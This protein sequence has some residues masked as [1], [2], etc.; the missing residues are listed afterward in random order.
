MRNDPYFADVGV[1]AIV[2]DVWGGPW[3]PRHHILTRLATYFHV[4]WVNPARSWQD[5]W[6]HWKVKDRCADSDGVPESGFTIYEPERWLPLVYR[7]H[8][9]AQFTAQKRLRQARRLLQRK[10]CKNII[11]YVWRPEYEATLDFIEADIKC[12]H[13]DDEYTFSD[14]EQ[15][16]GEVEAKLIS[17]VDQIFIHSP[18]L[19]EKKGKLNPNT[20]FIPNGVDYHAY[21]TPRNEPLDLALIP[22]PRIGY[23][24]FIKKQLDWALLSALVR[25]HPDWSFV[26]VGPHGPLGDRASIVEKVSKFSNVY[27]LGNKSVNALP[28]YTQHLDVCMLCYEVNEYTKFIYPLKLHEYLASGRPIVGTPIRSL[29]EFGHVITLAR[30]AEEWSSALAKA[31][32]PAAHSVDQ[33]ETRRQIAREYDWKVQVWRIARTLCERLGLAYLERFEKLTFLLPLYYLDFVR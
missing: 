27:F 18:G 9:L 22:K 11:L 20:E 13:I 4:I 31:L 25:S 7:P 6:M 5:L 19:L 14:I 10:R 33:V 26:F 1:I 8:I 30:T 23:I 2:P 16:I 3:Q 12:Y 21:A 28:A 17:R 32:A 29:M 24:G 15:P